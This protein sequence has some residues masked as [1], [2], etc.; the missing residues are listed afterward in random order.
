MKVLCSQEVVRPYR[1]GVVFCQGTAKVSA[2]Q[3]PWGYLGAWLP[4]GYQVGRG[5]SK[6]ID[7]YALSW[8]V[9]RKPAW[10]VAETA[11]RKSQSC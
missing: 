8:G 3:T 11:Q 9:P 2:R 4:K 7:L 5:C 6:D 10:N 1:C